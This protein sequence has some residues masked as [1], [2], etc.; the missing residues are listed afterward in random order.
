MKKRGLAAARGA[1]DAEKFSGLDLQIN[2]VD[3]K[4]AFAALGAVTEA[5]FAQGHLGNLCPDGADGAQNCG[6]S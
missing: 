3:G 1:N 2:V 5:D 6:G 4:Q